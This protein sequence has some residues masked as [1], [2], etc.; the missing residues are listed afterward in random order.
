MSGLERK[1]GDGAGESRAWPER[2]LTSRFQHGGA[3][4]N[5]DGSGEEAEP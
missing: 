1:A 2:P 4:A 3:D 5:L